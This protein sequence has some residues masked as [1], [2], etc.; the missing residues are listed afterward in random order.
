MAGGTRS[1][2]SVAA[3]GWNPAGVF[4]LAVAVLASLPLFGFGLAGLAAAWARPE[5]SHGPVIPVLSFYMF[6]HELKGVPPAPAGNRW[7]GVA[8]IGLGLGLALV[9][10]LVQINDLAFYALIVWTF[11][12]VLVGF[13]ARRG[14]VFWPSVLHLVF[15]LPL[16]QF[17]YWQ[18]STSLQ[19]VS[20]E[21]G[22]A[23]VR[24]MGVPVYLEGN[25]IDLGIYQ[26]QVA[27]ACSGLRYLFPIM[28]FTYVFAVLY[29][30]PVWHKL[31]LLVS[32]VPLAVL[33]NSL[34]IGV[35]GLLVDRHGIA[36]AEGFL[37]V[38]E[39]WVI[40]LLC[41]AILFL[42]AKAMQR[43]SGDR[44]PLGA[45]LD[46]DFSGL[47]R[48]AGRIRGVEASA[49]LIAAAG[50]TAALS[51]A[52]ALAPERGAARVAR[53][54]FAL[55]P[56]EIDGWQGRAE[57]RARAGDRGGARRRRLPGRGLRL[58]R[59]GRARRPLPLLLPRPDRRQ[60]DPLAGGLPARRRLGGLGDR[61]R[62]PSR[63][64]TP[65]P[66]PCG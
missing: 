45:A 26:L 30:G 16:P 53:D 3:A 12:L 54:S 20:S 40:F 37:H 51:L 15:M 46:L 42:M 55:F 38:F 29:R 35:I 4:W 25:V 65:R 31:V 52:F 49:A 24:A 63:C 64:P 41:I 28:S 47:G 59:G 17:L 7:P 1:A 14:L 2:G 18:V 32:A 6:L 21:I 23:L 58:A 33:M 56:R 22:V 43:L 44:R 48:E 60:R 27:E 5:Y 13:G 34:R 61:S 57:R 62:S 9:G 19:F 11:G 66:E 50:L 10:N 8:V 36:Q 39:G